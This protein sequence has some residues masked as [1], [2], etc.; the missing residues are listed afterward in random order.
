MCCALQYCTVQCCAS[1]QGPHLEQGEVGG[2][3]CLIGQE[4]VLGL[5]VLHS[6]STREEREGGECTSVPIAVPSAL[7]VLHKSHPRGTPK[8]LPCHVAQELTHSNLSNGK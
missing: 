4:E 1:G 3:G 6:K 8:H 5:L 2:G 7:F